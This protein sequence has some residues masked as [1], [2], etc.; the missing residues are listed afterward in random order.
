[1]ARPERFLFEFED[2]SMGP[3]SEWHVAAYWRDEP[4]VHGWSRLFHDVTDEDSLDNAA[5]VTLSTSSVL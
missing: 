4:G 2:V 5:G 3:E 1:M